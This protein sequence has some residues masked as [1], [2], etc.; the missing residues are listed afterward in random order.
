[1]LREQ[2]IRFRIGRSVKYLI[3]ATDQSYEATHGVGRVRP[4]VPQVSRYDANGDRHGAV[5]AAPCG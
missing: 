1:M 5:G 2:N 4:D 3:A